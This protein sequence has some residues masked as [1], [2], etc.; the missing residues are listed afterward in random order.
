[1]NTT[2]RLIAADIENLLGSTP[3]HATAARWDSAVA[4]LTETLAYEPTRDH[5]VVAVHPSWAFEVKT[6]IPT[7]RLLVRTGES[8]ADI[9]L[10]EELTDVT[11]IAR[12]YGRVVV[13]S[14]DHEF[15]SPVA[16]L[17]EAGVPVT[18]A[19]VALHASP[20]LTAMATDVLWLARPDVLVVDADPL[21]ALLVSAG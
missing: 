12:R 19:S 15:V 7:A 13:A 10:C 3:A 17:T 21:A 5:L 9:A 2:R 8:G 14:G 18:V 16:A 20:V 1:M 4:T 11:F 6:R